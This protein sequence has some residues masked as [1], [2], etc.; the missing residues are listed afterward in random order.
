MS[1]ETSTKIV[2]GLGNPGAKYKG[3]RHNV[4]FE[5]LDWL[6][7]HLSSPLPTTKYEGQF[8]AVSHNKGKLLMVWPF[9]YMNHSGRCVAAFTNFYKID[10]EQDLM[11]VCDD[12]SLPTGK[13]RIRP[14]GSAGGQKGLN[15][16]LQSLKT[17]SI[18]RLRIG[19]DQ[20]P[21]QWETADYVLGKFRTEEKE[22][23]D[24]AIQSAG[25]AVLDWLEHDLNHC[26]N[27]YN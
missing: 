20:T 18:P 24:E 16:I 8:T 13:L 12:L 26:M 2:V 25:Q 15:H 11:V 14:K 4:G 22:I 7:R 10:V 6:S 1:A 23:I 9:T 19:I 17:Q 21:P 5:V 3:T 27:Q